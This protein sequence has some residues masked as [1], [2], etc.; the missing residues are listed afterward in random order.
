ME[1]PERPERVLTWVLAAALVASMVAVVA[2]ALNPPD[3][4]DPY[5]EFYVLGPSGNASGYPTN[6]SVGG[7][8]EVIVGVSNHEDRA[9]TY[10]VV[11]T[12]NGQATKQR[13]VRVADGATE[14]FRVRLQA[15]A[16]PGRYRVR[17]LLFEGEPG[18]EPY[19]WLRLWVT[20]GNGTANSSGTTNGT[21]TAKRTR[22]GIGNGTTTGTGTA[23]GTR[24]WIG[25]GTTTGNW[26][27]TA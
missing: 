3:T 24:A 8:G 20:V 23:K 9:V 27:A 6:V 13:S 19:R 12:W 26:T 15:P 7:S 1:L 16:E 18:G 21:G 14:E 25:N 17:F 11:V 22:A 2:I 4:T 5:T 10:R